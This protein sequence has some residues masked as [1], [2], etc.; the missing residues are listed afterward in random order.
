MKTTKNYL[1]LIIALLI[2]SVTVVSA[3]NPE[4]K[5][6]K[7]PVNSAIRYQV[8]INLPS[9]QG[10]CTLYQVEILDGRGYQVAPAKIL[11]PGV[12]LYDFYERGPVKGVRIARLV[13]SP[14]DNGGHL[15]NGYV[16]C[17]LEYV[18]QPVALNGLFE[19]GQTYKFELFP[20][21][22]SKR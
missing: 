14:I 1:L 12:A 18:T 16:V 22:Q 21:V 3:S 13:K 10:V 6:T 7:I 5:N 2:S 17:D 8:S 20:Q 9:E 4:G 19:N 15:G 11:V